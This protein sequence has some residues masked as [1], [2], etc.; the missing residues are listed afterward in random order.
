MFVTRI[1][2]DLQK[3]LLLL[4][5]RLP[6]QW[7][8]FNSLTQGKENLTA[9]AKLR[10]PCPTLCDLIDGSPTG[11]SVPGILLARILLW[12]AISFSNAWKWKV[13]VKS[14]NHIRLLGTPWMEAQQAP[15]S[16]GFSSQEYWSGLPLPSPSNGTKHLLSWDIA[17]VLPQSQDIALY[18]LQN[19]NNISYSWNDFL[20]W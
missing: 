2:P 16:M 19:A 9:T 13:K 11:S 15:Q 18:H 4:F 7:P 1:F 5:P 8:N 10:A 6:I 17:L 20:P 12:V 3:S 14:L